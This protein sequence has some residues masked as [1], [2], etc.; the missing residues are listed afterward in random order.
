MNTNIDK[1]WKEFGKD[2]K[3]VSVEYQPLSNSWKVKYCDEETC[4]V[5]EECNSEMY[6]ASKAL[7]EW[8]KN[9]FTYKSAAEHMWKL[10]DKIAHLSVN[11]DDHIYS[12]ISELADLRNNFIKSDGETLVWNESYKDFEQ[13]TKTKKI[14]VS[15]ATESEKVVF[16]DDGFPPFFTLLTSSLTINEYWGY[17]KE[18]IR[19]HILINYTN[20]ENTCIDNK[21]INVTLDK[22]SPISE[23]EFDNYYREA[24]AIMN[25]MK[26]GYG[27]DDFS[28]YKI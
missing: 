9:L 4:N 8:Y 11:N 3:F 5:H 25:A 7:L 12:Q 18:G 28:K 1:I 13:P 23:S 10:L 19:I 15:P 6:D 16:P 26:N 17:N 14:D 2:I 27:V 24:I 22:V 21:P 20:S